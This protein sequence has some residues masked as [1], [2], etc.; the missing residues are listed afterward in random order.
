MQRRHLLRTAGAGAASLAIGRG[1]LAAGAA[2]DPGLPTGTIGEATL[3]A[4]PGKSK[5]IKLTYRPPNYEA[6]LSAFRTAITR[7]EDFFVRYHLAAIPEMPDLKTWSLKI[8]GDAAGKSISFTLDTLKK[9]FRAYDITAVCQ[10][11]GN[12]RGLSDPHVAGVEWGVG[13]MA[14]ARWTGVRLA[15]VL[16]AA[17]VKP[18]AVEIAFDGADGPLIDA[19]PDFVKSIPLAKA[20]DNDVLIAFAMN[21]KPLPHL[22]GYP[23]RIVVPGWTATY[24]MKHVTTIEVRSAPLASFWMKAAYRVPTGMFPARMAFPT[25]DTAANVPITDILVNSLITAPLAGARVAGTGFDI[26][27]IAWDGGSGIRTVEVSIDGGKTWKPARLGDD[28]GRFSFRA[29]SLHVSGQ[30]KGE[31]TILARAVSGSGETQAEKLKFN[32][33]G[34]HNN[35]PRPVAVTVA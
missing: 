7:N 31:T 9:Q 21:G 18:E 13:A 33:A 15:D 12:R 30:T 28:L 17:G 29:F 20:M 25:Q 8:G 19:T 26:Q 5:L 14:N 3:E 6:P 22:N 35:V 10:C 24:W 1:A 34:Y 4:L 32:P 23:A 27:G 16:K 11:S 2:T